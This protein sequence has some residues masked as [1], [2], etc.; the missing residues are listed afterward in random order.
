MAR[1]R[2]NNSFAL[3]WADLLVKE[4]TRF[5]NGELKDVAFDELGFTSI[6]SWNWIV[7]PVWANHDLT[8][9]DTFND[10]A[11]WAINYR[12]GWSCNNI[13]IAKHGG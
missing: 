6:V 11:L 10:L 13:T 7:L 4:F 8:I 12:A 9:K 5:A 3:N 2:T 1:E